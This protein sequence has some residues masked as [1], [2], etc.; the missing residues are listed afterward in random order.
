VSAATPAPG[1]HPDTL[2][3]AV[4]ALGWTT[5]ATTKQPV[6]ELVMRELTEGLIRAR[7]QRDAYS[8]ALEEIETTAR[9]ILEGL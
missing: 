1:I 8:A 9:E 6:P 4:A 2:R 3:A 7:F 5:A